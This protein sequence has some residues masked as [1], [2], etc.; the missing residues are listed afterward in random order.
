MKSRGRVDTLPVAERAHNLVN[1]ALFVLEALAGIYIRN[2]DN[3]F[4]RRV[5]HLGNRIHISPGVEEVANIKRLEPSVA[6]ELLIVGVRHRLKLVLFRR[7]QHGLAV[8]T[9]V[10]ARHGNQ[11][12]LVAGDK[13]AQLATQFVIRVGRNVVEFVNGNQAVVEGVDA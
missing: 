12:H 2:M 3:G 7:G 13:G 6:I 1:F 8:T 10:G 9:E 11:V 4:Q 5:Q